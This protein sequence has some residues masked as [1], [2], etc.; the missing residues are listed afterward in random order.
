[1]K[2]TRQT[3]LKSFLE[4][5]GPPISRAATSLFNGSIVESIEAYSA[6]LRGKGGQGGE[7]SHH[8]EVRAALEGISRAD[9]IVFDVGAAHGDWSATMLEKV[10]KA[11]IFMIEP[12]PSSQSAIRERR[13]PNV[14]LC[15]YA[16]GEEQGGATLFAPRKASVV[17]SFHKRSDSR[18]SNIEYEE[19]V[20]PVRTL[21]DVASEHNLSFIDFV[22]MDIE[23]HE[24][25]A[26]RGA[27]SLFEDRRVGALSFEFGPGNVNS[28]TMFIDFFKF[29]TDYGFMIYRILPGGRVMS[30]PRYDED[31]EFYRGTCN[32]TARLNKSPRG[33]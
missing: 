27:A 17:A 26:L 3:A 1:M 2:F 30:I 22:K 28:R 9:P 4:I 21:S 29:L 5:T 7:R 13:L 20:V 8:W 11:R 16:L 14:V 12:Q 24:L 33:R 15:P 31:C 18:W 10:P 19:Y 32:Y 6:F 25:A 23:G